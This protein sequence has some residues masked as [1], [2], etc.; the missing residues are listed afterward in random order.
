MFPFG[1][2]LNL[3]DVHRERENHR[4]CVKASDAYVD[5]NSA[6]CVQAAPGRRSSAKPFL[7]GTRERSLRFV[8]SGQ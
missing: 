2:R 6:F 3:G 7:E 5:H 4:V 1:F 8:H